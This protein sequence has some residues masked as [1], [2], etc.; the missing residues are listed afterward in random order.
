MTIY[1]LRSLVSGVPFGILP[2]E[3]LAREL[4]CLRVETENEKR[5]EENGCVLENPTMTWLD[6]KS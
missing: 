3:K 2:I 5:R 6:L 1:H 4:H